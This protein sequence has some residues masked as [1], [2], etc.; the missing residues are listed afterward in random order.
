MRTVQ[1]LGAAPN[2]KDCPVALPADT[3]RWCL[4]NPFIYKH[5]LYP[6]AMETYTCWFNL[7]PRRQ[8]DK[9]YKSGV[10]WYREQDKPIY[11]QVADPS[12]PASRA[13]P[14]E[15]I[16]QHFAI[17][18]QPMRYFT[19]TLAWCMAHAIRLREFDCIDLQGFMLPQPR[20]PIGD[21][22]EI[23]PGDSLHG[24]QRPCVAYW[25][26]RARMIGIEVRVPPDVYKHGVFEPGDAMRYQGPLYGYET[27]YGFV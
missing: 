14:R 25:V 6:E 26:E 17:E 2:I 24:R 13:F 5:H 10:E 8:I 7:H 15:E 21:D 12:I 19:S 16:Q 4:N 27:K 11:L 1:I 20:F 18:R 9:L 22:T 23:R 3:E